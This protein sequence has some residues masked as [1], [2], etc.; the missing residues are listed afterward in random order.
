MQSKALVEAADLLIYVDAPDDIRLT[1]RI[2]RDVAERGRTIDSVLDQYLQTVRPM[3]LRYVEP[4][5]QCAHL[6]LDGTLEPEWILE[7]VVSEIENRQ[8]H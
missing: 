8:N 4:T 1:R 3:H 2:R 7:Q 6:V 5:R